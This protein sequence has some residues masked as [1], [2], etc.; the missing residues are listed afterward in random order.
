MA[1]LKNLCDRNLI[2]IVTCSNALA[3]GYVAQRFELSKAV[4]DI[5]KFIAK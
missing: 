3:M 5:K 1:S 2:R 4:D